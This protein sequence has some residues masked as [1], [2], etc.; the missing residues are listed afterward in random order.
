MDDRSAREALDRAKVMDL[1]A[2]YAYFYDEGELDE[3]IDLFWDDAVL[4]I[5]PDP[6]FFPLPLTGRAA[7]DVAYRGRYSEVSVEAR[8]RHIQSN[9]L[10]L[11]TSP[12][13]IRAATF[14]VAMS[15]PHGEGGVQLLG[16]GVYRD[17]FTCRDGIWRFQ[18]RNLI[19]DT[20]APS[21]R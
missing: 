17:L 6:G 13:E 21:G 3:F 19:M 15:V 12:T 18:E 2:G 14:L 8:R 1:I 10:F 4:D 5:S 11:S 20:L 16:T 9:T 7:I